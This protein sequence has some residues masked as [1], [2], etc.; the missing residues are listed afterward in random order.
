MASE[1]LAPQVISRLMGEVRELVRRPPEGVEYVEN[2]ENSVSEIHAIISGPEDTPFY[3]G[4]FRMKLVI[5]DEY[6]NVPPKGYFL[7]RIFH[8]NVSLSG[9]ICVNT[10]KRDWN[11][12]VTLKHILQVIRCLLI[13]PFPESSLNDEA[14]KLFMESYEEY[15]SRARI[16][17]QVHAIP[18]DCKGSMGKV[19]STDEDP[20]VIAG[21]EEEVSAAIQQKKKEKDIKKKNM[22]RL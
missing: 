8:P 16:M 21:E 22:K 5:S 4:K 3:G 13:I 17:T 14:G 12:D 7:T 2:E 11:C 18:A 19:S 1:N 6:P 15:A 10:L 20:A 9:D